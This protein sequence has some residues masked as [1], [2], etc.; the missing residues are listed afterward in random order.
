M[1][2]YL[3]FSIILTMR[4]TK[5]FEKKTAKAAA[6]TY[7][8]VFSLGLTLLKELRDFF[9]TNE[10]ILREGVPPEKLREIYQITNQIVPNKRKLY[11]QRITKQI[12]RA[13][14]EKVI[15]ADSASFREDL[16]LTVSLLERLETVTESTNER[17]IIP[18][19]GR[20]RISLAFRRSLPGKRLLW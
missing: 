18:F 7:K 1:L 13:A 8:E 10:H 17:D 6:Q 19:S 15:G 16:V 11:A 4:V 20:G 2:I 14:E 12:I 3:V 5:D 9:G